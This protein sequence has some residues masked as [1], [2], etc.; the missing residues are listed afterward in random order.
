MEKLYIRLF[1]K[2]IFTSELV[3][4]IILWIHFWERDFN[5]GIKYFL[6]N[7]TDTY[8]IYDQIFTVH[9]QT[10]THTQTHGTLIFYIYDKP[11]GPAALHPKDRQT[12]A[13]SIHVQTDS[14][15]LVSFCLVSLYVRS[16]VRKIRTA[17]RGSRICWIHQILRKP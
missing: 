16:Y 6:R 17:P 15:S 10:H 5:D 3:F 13:S 7:S 2:G 11:F 12:F 8:M 4:F 14:R 1:K 9:T